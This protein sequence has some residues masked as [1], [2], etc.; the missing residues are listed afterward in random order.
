LSDNKVREL[1]TVCG[2]GSS[3]Q[4]PQYG[5]MALAYQVYYLEILKRLCWRKR[6]QIFA[7]KSWILYHDNAPAHKALPVREL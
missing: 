6:P 4:K 5:L 1:A 2:R 3:G 7:N